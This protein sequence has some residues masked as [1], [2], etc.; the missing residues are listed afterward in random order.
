V[1]RPGTVRGSGRACDWSRRWCLG[2]EQSADEYGVLVCFGFGLLLL[3]ASLFIRRANVESA[4][5]I[6]KDFDLTLSLY[7]GANPQIKAI[8]DHLDRE[9]AAGHIPTALWARS[10][11]LPLGLSGLEAELPVRGVSGG[12]TRRPPGECDGTCRIGS[13]RD[14]RCRCRHSSAAERCLEVAAGQHSSAVPACGPRSRGRDS[15]DRPRFA[16]G[17]FRRGGR[18]R[19]AETVS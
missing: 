18:L 10:D 7:E 11:L 8:H 13:G 6:K 12:L 14:A 4:S 1:G 5:N 9:A 17:R 3:L 2:L 15:H 19:A 16:R